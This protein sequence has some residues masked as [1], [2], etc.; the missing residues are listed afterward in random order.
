MSLMEFL[1]PAP[2]RFAEVRLCEICGKKLNI[3]NKG[4][5]CNPH[6]PEAIAAHEKRENTRNLAVTQ[7]S[8]EQVIK[9]VLTQY[10]GLKLEHLQQDLSGRSL[11]D[12]VAEAQRMLVYLLFFDAKLPLLRIMSETGFAKELDIR[13]VLELAE[14]KYHSASNVR[15]KVAEIRR[16]YPAPEAKPQS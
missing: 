6:P 4:R 14:Y 2:V 12:P 8:P 15:R 1:G 3:Y 11:H 10:V 7:A 16:L 13:P 5:Y 9:S